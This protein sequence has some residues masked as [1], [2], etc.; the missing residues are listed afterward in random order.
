MSRMPP[1]IH[2]LNMNIFITVASLTI[3]P[4]SL[5]VDPQKGSSDPL[6]WKSGNTRRSSVKI[7]MFYLTDATVKIV[8]CKPA[9]WVRANEECTTSYNDIS[10][11]YLV[12]Q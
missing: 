5:E 7:D 9:R 3:C 6:P 1:L 2:K 11:L 10:F 12:Y 4:C 8:F